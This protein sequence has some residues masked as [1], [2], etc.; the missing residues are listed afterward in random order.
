MFSQINFNT[1]LSKFDSINSVML[2]IMYLDTCNAVKGWSA[3]TSKVDLSEY[4]S[5]SIIISDSLSAYDNKYQSTSIVPINQPSY[6]EFKKMF[7]NDLQIFKNNIVVWA[8]N[9]SI[10][11]VSI[12]NFYTTLNKY[13]S[14]SAFFKANSYSTPSTVLFCAMYHTIVQLMADNVCRN[15][16]DS[17]FNVF[18]TYTLSHNP[19]SLNS[20][21]TRLSN[22][23]SYLFNKH[24]VP[25]EDKIVLN[26][27]LQTGYFGDN[28]SITYTFYV[29]TIFKGTIYTGYTENGFNISN[30]DIYRWHDGKETHSTSQAADVMAQAKFSKDYKQTQKKYSDIVDRVKTF[31]LESAFFNL[32]LLRSKYL[33]KYTDNLM[34]IYRH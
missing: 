20:L 2:N 10:N 27:K 1:T 26:D 24:S 22:T 17:L 14:D 7:W 11:E 30:T 4:Q 16:I 3:I 32:T 28:F 34:K 25:S 13:L 23:S 19:S 33:R 6:V 9:P 18:S 21:S 15:R 31:N 5:I 8:A 12:K 29:Y